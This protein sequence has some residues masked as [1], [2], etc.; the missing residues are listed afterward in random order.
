MQFLAV[1]FRLMRSGVV[2]RVS[3]WPV[4]RYAGGKYGIHPAIDSPEC[5]HSVK[6]RRSGGGNGGYGGDRGWR[7]A[8]FSEEKTQTARP[9]QGGG[10]ADSLLEKVAQRNPAQSHC[11]LSVLE[12]S[13]GLANLQGQ[14][15]R[16]A[17]GNNRGG[18]QGKRS[19]SG[20]SAGGGCKALV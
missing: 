7:L 13:F 9:P 3:R 6:E 2:I 16:M 17:V 18:V 8:E 19:S 5:Q 10:G 11:A 1:F 4:C 12:S 15:K 14:G 20:R